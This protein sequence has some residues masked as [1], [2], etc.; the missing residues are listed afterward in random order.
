MVFIVMGVS[1]SGKT[2][3]GKMVA[4]RIALPFHD[5]DDFHSQEALLKMRQGIP[6]SD[7]ER[8]PWLFD[9]ALHVA[10]WN[11]HGGAVLACSA[12]KEKYRGIL[13]WNGK[14][15]VSFIYLKGPRE[16]ILARMK[17]SKGRFFPPEMLD[18]QLEALEEPLDAVIVAIGDNSEAVCSFIVNEIVRADLLPQ[19]YIRSLNIG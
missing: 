2:T 8:V 17:E 3:I 1:G 14:E 16:I 5:A 9:L 15:S 13:T 11:R 4:D 18:S 6:L 7:D 12:L 10:Q 19:S